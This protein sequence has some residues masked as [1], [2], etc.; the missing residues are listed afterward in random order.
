MEY[1]TWNDC[2]IKINE[3]SEM[4]M[5]FIKVFDIVSVQQER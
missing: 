5:D 4:Y 3:C 2:T 1:I